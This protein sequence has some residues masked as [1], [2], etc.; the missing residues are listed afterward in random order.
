MGPQCRWGKR[1]PRSDSLFAI[2]K[3]SGARAV[4]FSIDGCRRIECF[5]GVTDSKGLGFDLLWN[6]GWMNDTL[7]Y[8]QTSHEHRRLLITFLFMR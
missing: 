4:S 7:K 2:F 8:F 3:P 5:P 1:E 6:L